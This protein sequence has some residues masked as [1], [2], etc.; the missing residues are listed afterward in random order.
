MKLFGIG[1]ALLVAGAALFIET[2]IIKDFYEAF[3]PSELA[4]SERLLL[5][6]PYISIAIMALGV[7]WYWIVEPIL[8]F[9]R[10]REW[11]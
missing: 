2:T 11:E 9:R 1:L 7:L 3:A 4:I 6:T 10:R 5:V 8:Y